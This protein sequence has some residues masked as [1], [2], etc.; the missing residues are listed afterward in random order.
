MENFETVKTFDDIMEHLTEIINT[1]VL[2]EIMTVQELKDYFGIV[3]TA[4]IR[5][6]EAMGLEDC[7]LSEQT[8][9]YLR[10]DIINFM[11]SIKGKK[12]REKARKWKKLK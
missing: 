5:K 2:K 12:G 1:P 10:E 11:K 7:Y 6:M 8:R 9:F 3:D 4:T